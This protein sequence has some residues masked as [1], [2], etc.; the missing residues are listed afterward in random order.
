MTTASPPSRGACT[1]D[2]AEEVHRRT[3][4][5]V[6]KRFGGGRHRQIVD[7]AVGEA[8][9]H[10]LGTKA[11][12]GLHAAPEHAYWLIKRVAWLLLSKTYS[13]GARHV[14]SCAQWAMTEGFEGDGTARENA[15]TEHHFREF[16]GHSS[17]TEHEDHFLAD[18]DTTRRL[19]R[20]K[21]CESWREAL[22]SLL[23]RG[24]TSG[25]IGLAIGRSQQ[26]VS[27]W[28]T[29]S[30]PGQAARLALFDLAAQDGPP[31]AHIT[32]DEA[33]R[34]YSA[35]PGARRRCPAPPVKRKVG[36]VTAAI[37]A[38]AP[39]VEV[40]GGEGWGEALDYLIRRGWSCAQLARRLGVNGAAA[41][42][43]ASR[44]NTPAAE[45]QAALIALAVAGE[46][47]PV[48]PSKSQVMR[49]YYAQ[50]R[51]TGSAPTLESVPREDVTFL[52]TDT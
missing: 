6:L 51:S 15:L 49:E 16:Y 40:F 2:L 14:R 4:V 37:R 43:W 44:R 8:F 29:R 19:L 24:W 46:G 34:L 39:A 20:G 47:P 22:G 36:A 48:E 45:R 12:K 7:D 50:R 33:R 5:G 18:L 23:N 30:V 35:R 52:S 17:P 26:A 27:Y 25:Q 41:Q 9:M 21:V 31:P 10:W 32:V 28:L 3:M 38:A 11:N 42:T 1:N 13:Q